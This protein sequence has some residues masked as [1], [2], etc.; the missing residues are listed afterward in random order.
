MVCSG[1]GRREMRKNLIERA[2]V[3]P[4]DQWRRIDLP[5]AKG[6]SQRIR[7]HDGRCT[8]R[9]YEGEARKVVLSDHGRKK[10]TFLIT[11]DFAMDVRDI[12]HK[13]ARR[14]LVEQEIAEQV[15]FFQLNHPSSPIVVKVDFDLTLSLLAHNLYRRLA[16]HLPGFEQCTADTINRKFLQNG[17]TVSIEGNTATVHLKKK[18][19]LPILFELPWMKQTTSLSWMN[20]NIRFAAGTTS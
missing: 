4:N 11:N 17:A 7:V 1:F 16:Q 13:Y 5:R 10:P 18:T 2:E 9:H 14:W 6:K 20:L 12:V 3:I 15:L 19:H 8:L